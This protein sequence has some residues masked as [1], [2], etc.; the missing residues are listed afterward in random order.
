MFMITY[1]HYKVSPSRP[2][3]VCTPWDELMKLAAIQT[4]VLPS[5]IEELTN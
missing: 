4:L 3:S 5:S 2:P 1:R